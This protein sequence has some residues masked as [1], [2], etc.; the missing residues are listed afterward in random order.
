MRFGEATQLDHR[1]MAP[2]V[3]S[4]AEPLRRVGEDSARFHDSGSMSDQPLD[5]AVQR[6]DP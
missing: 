2:T 5:R 3:G 6:E 4:H 1:F